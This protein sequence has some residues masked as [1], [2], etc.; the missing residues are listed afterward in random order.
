MA[1]GIQGYINQYWDDC[2]IDSL[3]HYITIPKVS[4]MF[5]PNLAA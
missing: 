1:K 3:K 5:D 4:R 2:I